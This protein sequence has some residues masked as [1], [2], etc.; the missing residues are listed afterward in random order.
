MSAASVNLADK[1][2][3]LGSETARVTGDALP[4]Q[5]FEGGWLMDSDAVA[6][7]FARSPIVSPYRALGGA[8]LTPDEI[9]GFCH[10]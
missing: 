7:D 6:E 8:Y 1:A 10:A 5:S 4:R 3:L 2:R 9:R